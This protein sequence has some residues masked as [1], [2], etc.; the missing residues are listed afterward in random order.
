MKRK[1]IKHRRVTIKKKLPTLLEMKA[2][3]AAARR[4]KAIRDNKT[5]RKNSRLW[6][7]L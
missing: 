6:S 2:K 7:G 1:I 3:E 4:R 5:Q